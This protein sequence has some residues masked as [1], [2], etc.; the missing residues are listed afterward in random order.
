MNNVGYFISKKNI[1]IN[2]DDF[3]NS[4]N[5][6]FITG[7][8]GSGKSTLSKYYAIK[9][10]ATI[11]ELDCFSNFNSN[12]FKNSL[13]RKITGK[14]YKSQPKIS[15]I[16][17]KGRYMDLKLNHFNDYVYYNNK[18]LEYICKYCEAHP[19]QNFIVEGT[20]L[21][22]T[23]DPSYFVDKSLIIIRT[24]A[25]YSFIRR[26][27]RQLTSKEKLHPFTY[28]KSH[29]RKLLNDSK[30]LHY[31]DVEKLNSFLKELGSDIAV[32]PETWS[33]GYEMSE[34][35]KA[36]EWK[37]KAIENDNT[38]L[39]KYRELAKELEMSIAITYLEK[40]DD[41]PKN[42]MIIY[43]RFGNVVLKDSKVHT[44]DF[45]EEKYTCLGKKFVSGILDYKRGQLNI[46]AMI[47]F[48]RD[49]P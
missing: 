41:L 19:K 36:K 32:F 24:S 38:Y 11:L 8:S 9:Y 15:D 14:F 4:N 13:I 7:L 34:D 33:N 17:K 40:T 31:R 49:F 43:D 25:F 29:L 48:D 22:M 1:T 47:C 2:I 20:Q 42:S 21:F 27:N 37:D 30:R 12:K 5:I 23:I 35:D 46:G 18:Y 39:L 45:K 44:V 26:L 28:G 10:N 16:I 6:L 3:D